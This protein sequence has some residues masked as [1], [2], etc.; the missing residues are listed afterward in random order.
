M[1][2]VQFGLWVAGAEAKRMPQTCKN[3]GVE[4]SAPGTPLAN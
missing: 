1:V 4:D 2:V 3:W